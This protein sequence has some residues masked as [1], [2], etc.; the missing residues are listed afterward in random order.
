MDRLKQHRIDFQHQPRVEIERNQLQ[1][2]N[3]LFEQVLPHNQFYRNKLGSSRSLRSLDELGQLPF[4]YKDEL[5]DR[6]GS[7]YATNLTF[8]LER[9]A[10]IHRTSG[11]R[12]RPLVVLD[13]EEDWLWWMTSWQYVLDA[14]NVDEQD[15]AVMAFSFGPF[16][17][18]W[19]AFDAAHF[20]NILV[21]PTGGM[22]TLARLELIQTMQATIV[23]CTPSYALRMAEVAAE[24]Q[25]LIDSLGVR[26]LIVAGE[27][28]GS[29]PSVRQKIESTWG[30]KVID[31]AGA[32]EV[33][34][35][36]FS[37]ERQQGL[38]LN[39]EDFIAEFL[40]VETGQAANSGELSELV[41]TTLGRVGSPVIR[42][43]TGDLV[44]PIWDHSGDSNFVLLEGGVLSR[45]DDMMVVRGVNVFPSSIEQILHGFPEIIEY[46]I[47]VSK[48]GAMDQ[49][50]VEIEDRLERPARVAKELQLRLGL[51]VEV[52]CVPLGT[53]PRF[54]LK[55]KR[56]I[57]MRGN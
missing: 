37:D 8:P 45:V 38:Y 9:Y 26:E 23:F 10:R 1:R 24:N 39:E 14:G 4:T 22:N 6:H 56:F 42:Y 18:F 34:A 12:G 27:P 5:M 44:K 33:G 19:S 7:Q 20:R 16:I 25:I 48:S 53:L 11:T 3:Q 46:R 32:S 51:R 36:G 17:G 49:L 50:K 2:L 40:S 52:C 57:D 35:W 21:A 30:A 29:I 55:G 41:I 15:R 31:H 54:E 47:T 28:G 13:T 43:R